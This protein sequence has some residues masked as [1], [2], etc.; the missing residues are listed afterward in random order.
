MEYFEVQAIEIAERGQALYQMTKSL[1]WKPA[2]NHKN[3]RFCRVK[4]LMTSK[5]QLE[6][7]K[8]VEMV[9]HPGGG[10]HLNICQVAVAKV[11]RQCKSQPQCAW[12]EST[13]LPELWCQKGNLSF[14][15]ESLVKR[16]LGNNDAVSQKLHLPMPEKRGAG[17]IIRNNRSWTPLI[18]R[19]N[20]CLRSS[21]A[22]I[23]QNLKL[24]GNKMAK[25]LH[26]S[27]LVKH[28]CAYLSRVRMSFLTDH[29]R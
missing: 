27:V 18:W 20:D 5:P 26:I 22:S 15:K 9:A 14:S 28:R 19:N 16:K 11:Q 8:I 24:E 17:W 6:L 4:F 23:W 3:G 10:D 25:M 12:V 13:G 29:W 1:V 7:V 21:K 2:S